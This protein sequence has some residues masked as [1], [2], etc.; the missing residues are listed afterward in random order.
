[1]YVMREHATYV[2]LA[3][4]LCSGMI[5]YAMALIFTQF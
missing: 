2:M 1:M 5:I 3:S 4:L